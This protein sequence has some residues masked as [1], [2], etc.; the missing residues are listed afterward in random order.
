MDRQ[1]IASAHTGDSLDGQTRALAHFAHF[2]PFH[3]TIHLAAWTNSDFGNFET[4]FDDCHHRPD[5]W[6]RLTE[7]ARFHL[8]APLKD[9]GGSRSQAQEETEEVMSLVIT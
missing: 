2:P 6:K 3:V 4:Q 1:E 7:L 8:E 9:C 5:G